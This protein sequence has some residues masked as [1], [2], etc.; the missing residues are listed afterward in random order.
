MRA[1]VGS[2]HTNQ[3]IK[4][5]VNMDMIEYAIRMRKSAEEQPISK[6][7]QSV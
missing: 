1:E 5:I 2:L 3:T 4:W 6:Q 7:Q